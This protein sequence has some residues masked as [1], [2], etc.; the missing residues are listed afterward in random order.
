MA[1]RKMDDFECYKIFIA[2]KSHFSTKN[3]AYDYIKYRGKITIR[4]DSYMKRKD[5]NIFRDLSKKYTRK[6]L[7][8]YFLSVFL[9]S[10][11][12]GTAIARGEFLSSAEL[13]SEET[14]DYYKLWKTRNQSLSYLF[15]DDFRKI[16]DSAIDNRLS[17]NEIFKSLGGDYPLIMQMERRGIISI[18]TLVILD[19]ILDFLEDVKMRDTIYWPI[20]KRKCKK[21][22]G[23][24]VIN[25]KSYTKKVKEILLD[26]YYEEYGKL[27][28]K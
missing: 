4:Q 14:Q 19:K 3:D 17:F 8:E 11:E 6:E 22:S 15:E 5:R 27:L 25:S 7:E 12:H 23:F 2:M 24:L 1:S 10:N 28:E 26:D 16:I 18:E 20:Y 21:Y 9:S 13:L